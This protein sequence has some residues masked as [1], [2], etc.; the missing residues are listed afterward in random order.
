MTGIQGDSGN[1]FYLSI[2]IEQIHRRCVIVQFMKLNKI[3]S[4]LLGTLFIFTILGSALASDWVEEGVTEFK[5]PNQQRVRQEP[6]PSNNE[7]S[8]FATPNSE[9]SSHTESGNTNDTSK[10]LEATITT[11]RK[12]Y[13]R[14]S[15]FPGLDAYANNVMENAP[16]LPRPGKDEAVDPSEFKA[17]LNASH[18]GAFK[19][20]KR[21]TILEVK[22]KWD[23]SGHVLRSFGIP[24]KRVSGGQI[25][26]IDLSKV[27][28]VVV[29]CAGDLPADAILRLRNFVSK[30]GLFANYRL[31]SRWSFKKSFPGLCHLEWWLYSL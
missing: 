4:V 25:S 14:P 8:V 21:E 20:I 12:D 18:P 3:L 26:D 7:D 29:N 27:Y 13:R 22:G 24:H 23:D 5:E 15:K 2:E 31:G 16:M 6:P 19:N 17:W 28:V 10:P 11:V 1:F 30:G 9:T